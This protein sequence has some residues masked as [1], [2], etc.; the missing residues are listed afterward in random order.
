MT[1]SMSGVPQRFRSKISFLGGIREAFM[2]AFAGIFFQVQ[3]RNADFLPPAASGGFYYFNPAVFGEGVYLIV[4]SGTPWARFG[5][6]VVLAGKDGG[7]IL[8]PQ[9]RAHGGE[10]GEFYGLFAVQ[11]G[12]CAWPPEADWTDVSVGWGAE[13]GRTGTEDLAQ[14]QKLNVDLEADD[15]LVTR[16]RAQSSL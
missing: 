2:Q 7:F 11:H 10:C 4:K 13:S 1:I 15:W 9:L 3:A 16:C 14:R 5:V 12:Q 8:T 6:E